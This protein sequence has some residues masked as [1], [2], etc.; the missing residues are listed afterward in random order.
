MV[1]FVNIK[2][3]NKIHKPLKILNTA[4]S[5]LLHLIAQQTNTIKRNKYACFKNFI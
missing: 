4:A 3:N 2:Y 1:S 5:I